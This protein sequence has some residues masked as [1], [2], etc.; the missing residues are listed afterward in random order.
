MS[1]GLL[2]SGTTE[3]RLRNVLH[4]NS[5]LEIKHDTTGY[6]HLIEVDTFNLTIYPP[7][8]GVQF[9]K[10]GIVFLSP[11]KNEV[12]ML[13][14]HISFGTIEAYYAKLKDS[15]LGKHMIFSPS[16]SFLYPCEAITFSHDFNL[17]YF[18]KFHKKDKK[19]KIFLAKYSFN[20]KK[21]SGWF[22]DKMPLDFCKD[23]STYTHPSLSADGN[24]L[25]FA[26]NK[27]GSLGGMDLFIT[28]KEGD[29][30]SVP[31]NLGKLINTTG[32]EIFPF[33][34]SENNLFFSS[35]RL[36][37][38]GGYDIFTCKF[39]GEAWDKPINLSRRINSGI[40]DI[41]FTIDKMDGKTAFYTKRKKSVKGDM[42]LFMVTLNKEVADNNLLTI[43]YIFHGKPLLKTSLTTTNT[44]TKV[45]PV[46]AGLKKAEL[47]TEFLKK[48]TV[49]IPL[50]KIILS[51]VKK[52]EVKV[53]E[54]IAN[55]DTIAEK[56]PVIEPEP[57]VKQPE[58]KVVTIKPTIP[59][60]D[61]LKDV[62]I[63]RIQF[64]SGTRPQRDN[65]IIVNGE[66]YNTYEYYYLGEY[67]YTIGEFRT[68]APA[69]ELQNTCR[70]SGYPQA[71]VAAFKN[72]TRSLDLKLFK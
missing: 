28:R 30:W 4:R 16:S 42:Q 52:E 51:E 49:P 27:K 67:R 29:K 18:T 59:T 14:K 36:P 34:D 41:A 21:R 7:S 10:D 57:K 25:I 24:I 2:T 45:K 58:A 33:L 53:P 50:I 31:E 17:M 20:G 26:S 1:L 38:Y 64:L 65:Q 11:S 15:I 12:K 22:P 9:Y 63:Y 61:D 5:L 23:N 71:F 13:P 72:N 56:K 69:I 48:D 8:T 3:K 60:P 35:D 54:T 66:S 46:L 43:S 19:E 39:N 6:I 68:L 37:G 55:L 44:V 32:N 47:K 62:V 70:R 40:D